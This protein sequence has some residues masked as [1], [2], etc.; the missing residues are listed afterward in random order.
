MYHLSFKG[1]STTGSITKDDLDQTGNVVCGIDISAI[2]R[3]DAD[4]LDEYASE[5]EKCPLGAEERKALAS[6]IMGKLDL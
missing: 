4:A 1:K 5:I 2:S 6:N 3:L